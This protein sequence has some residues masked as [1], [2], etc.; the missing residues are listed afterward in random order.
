MAAAAWL[1]GLARVLRKPS[2]TLS[3]GFLVLFIVVAFRNNFEHLVTHFGTVFLPVALLNGVALALGYGLALAGRLPKEDRR[4]VCIEV[5]IQNTPLALVLVFNFFN[6]LG[7]MAMI[8]AWW[9]IWHIVL[10]LTL[11]TVW[12]RLDR[13]ASADAGASM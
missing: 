13:R 5:G 8:A 9:G 1:P 6:G 11:A 2:K 12:T 4:A 10:G 7:G 3:I